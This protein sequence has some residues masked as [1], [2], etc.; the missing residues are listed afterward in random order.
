MV[1]ELQP[2]QLLPLRGLKGARLVCLRGVLW[3]T[4]DN[5]ARDILLEPGQS[6]QLDR[7][8][9][10]VQA[11]GASRMAIEALSAPARLLRDRG[12]AFSANS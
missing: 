8:T 3:V 12:P 9:A 10:T 6:W 1:L 2:D 4:H 11:I 7:R 5:D